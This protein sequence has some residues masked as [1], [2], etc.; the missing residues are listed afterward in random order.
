[1]CFHI[2]PCQPSVL[3]HFYP[4]SLPD[5]WNLPGAL[6]SPYTGEPWAPVFNVTR[7]APRVGVDIRKWVGREVTGA[8]DAMTK[9][10]RR[11]TRLNLQLLNKMLLLFSTRMEEGGADLLLWGSPCFTHTHMWLQSTVAVYLLHQSRAHQHCLKLLFCEIAHTKQSCQDLIFS[12][13]K[14]FLQNSGML[15]INPSGSSSSELVFICL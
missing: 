8:S 14:H 15:P 11:G 12:S 13:G 1:M 4:V 2:L 7:L 5:I 9:L 3:L 6:T 10:L